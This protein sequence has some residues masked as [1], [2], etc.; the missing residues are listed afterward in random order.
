MDMKKLNL[1]RGKLTETIEQLKEEYKI[2]IENKP[3]LDIYKFDKEGVPQASLNVYNNADGTTTLHHKTGANQKLSLE[4][5]NHIKNN[6]LITEFKSNSFYLKA[7]RDED[8][9]VLK[10]RKYNRKY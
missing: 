5:A 10:R 8:F 3:N 9:D 7:I 6:C 4:I 1:D 2:S